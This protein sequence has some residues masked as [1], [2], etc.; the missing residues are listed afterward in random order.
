MNRLAELR[1]RCEAL[2]ERKA[3]E[4]LAELDRLST[5]AASDPHWQRFEMKLKRAEW[6]VGQVHHTPAQPIR[7][8]RQ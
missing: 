1:E 3:R 7:Q 6:L 4:Y 8:G 2:P 5:R